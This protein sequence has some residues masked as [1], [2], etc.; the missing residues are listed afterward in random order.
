MAAW[1]VSLML[2]NWPEVETSSMGGMARPGQE[3]TKGQVGQVVRWPVA[4]LGTNA[5]GRARWGQVTR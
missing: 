2:T 4:R 3:G 5:L 1:K